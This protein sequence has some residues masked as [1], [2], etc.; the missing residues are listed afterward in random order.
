MHVH[1]YKYGDQSLI[2]GIFLNQ[3]S[4]NFLRQSISVKLKLT[5][6]LNW[7]ISKSQGLSFLT[8]PE[9]GLQ[10]LTAYLSITQGLGKQIQILMIG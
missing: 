5:S 4:L 7:M 3:S 9:L 8:L 1:A 6:C 2:L 10:T